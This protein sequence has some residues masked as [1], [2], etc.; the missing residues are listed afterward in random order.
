MDSLKTLMDKKEYDL[1]LKL[2]ENSQDAL[3][4]F[5]RLS[6]LVATSRVTEALMM[7]EQ[8]K[9][10]LMSKPTILM[11]F[12]IEILC[13]LGKFDEAYEALAFY[14]EQPYES[15]ETEELLRSLPKYI[16]EQEKNTYQRREVGQDEIR[17]KLLSK[18]NEEVLSA[19]DAVRS[20][21]LDSFLL[22]ILNILKT[23]PNQMVRAF[24]LLLLVAKK[25][26]KKVSFLHFNKIIEVTPSSLM[27]PFFVPNVGNLEKISALFQNS[28]HD[29]SVASNAINILSSYLIYIY[30]EQL[31]YNEDQLVVI[32]AYLSKE[33]LHISDNNLDVMC[34]KHGLDLEETQE[35][36]NKIKAHIANN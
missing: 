26:D 23:Y 30:P 33:L 6:A 11:K 19:L 14:Q 27:E 15:Q 3:A 18:N 36:I 28:F 1:V 16:R 32:F 12:H 34:E 24:A 5:Y 13:L 21:P 29:P 10:I 25:Y 20:Q 31:P 7:I 22:P 35:E 8:K 4:L 17:E 9:Q 2:T